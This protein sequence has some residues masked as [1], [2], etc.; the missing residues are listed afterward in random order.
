MA[1][2]N[3]SNRRRLRRLSRQAMRHSHGLKGEW[4]GGGI[5]GTIRSMEYNDELPMTND[6]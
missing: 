5:L 2:M 1:D 4:E 6:E 3:N